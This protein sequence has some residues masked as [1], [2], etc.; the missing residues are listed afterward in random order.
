MITIQD[1]TSNEHEQPTESE[2]TLTDLC[3]LELKQRG[4][5]FG[6]WIPFPLCMRGED[7]PCRY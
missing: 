2:A 6:W 3:E 4:G 5:L 7:L 1:L